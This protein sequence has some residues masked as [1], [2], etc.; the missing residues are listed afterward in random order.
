MRINRL[1]LTRYGHFTDGSIAFPEPAPGM[2]DLHIVYG[3]N[4]SG[5]ST[6]FIALVDLLFGIEPRSKYAF[7]HDY[8]T[9]QIGASLSLTSGTE[10]LIRVKRN[11][12]TLLDRHH[13]PVSEQQ[14]LT[15][16]SG[17]TRES[18]QTMF[19][20]DDQSIEAGGD[21]ILQ[22]RGDFGELLFGASAGLSNLSQRLAEIDAL[23]GAFYRPRA[24]SL[25]LTVLKDELEKLK[26]QRR[27]IDVAASEH[28]HLRANHASRKALYDQAV[29]D[30]ATLQA[31]A[32][33]L[34]RRS[35]ALPLWA[36]LRET[37]RKLAELAAIPVAPAAWHTDFA[38]LQRSEIASNAQVSAIDAEVAAIA[39][40][41]SALGAQPE[42]VQ[43]FDRLEGLA[44]SR[45]RYLT[46]A[47]DLPGR[48]QRLQ[49]D[50]I[51]IGSLLRRLSQDEVD[52]QTLILPTAT[53]GALRGLLE[54]HSGIAGDV[55][56]AKQEHEAATE[57]AET[58]RETL[59]QQMDGITE[60]PASAAS[61]LDKALSTAQ[62]DASHIKIR[63]TEDLLRAA[64]EDVDEAVSA[65]RPWQG[66]AD[67]L[68]RV[69]V[70]SD[71]QMS[72]WKSLAQSIRQTSERLSLEL[73]NARKAARRL[74]AEIDGQR[75]TS[76]LMTH[77]VAAKLRLD[78]DSAWVK[79]RAR[80]DDVTADT[81][82]SALALDDQ[83]T[84][85]R[86]MRL[87]ATT[88]LDQQTVQLKGAKA[89]LVSVE[90]AIAENAKRQATLDAAVRN[91]V[92]ALL[93]GHPD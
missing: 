3:P 33:K 92:A 18:Y 5:K 17:L 12:A 2:P 61:A 74:S 65:L 76:G 8:G 72:D 35:S 41:M 7:L 29:V 54:Q 27:S 20:L 24:R 47:R 88:K 91:C 9:M 56:R 10:E 23:A 63:H 14:L 89:E 70:P 22:S 1:D 71:H 66:S 16:L 87:E 69:A 75:E 42:L 83:A 64:K 21:L 53:V 84:L 6:T 55:R 46:A 77:D 52:P 28:A 81:F 26:E 50:D 48:R 93:A 82:E 51:L 78:R 62:R 67:D 43:A 15:E 49:A 60:A 73:E 44:E 85:T 68:V 40:A 58:H 86:M 90:M 34:A 59:K 30:Q 38:Q 57:I 13:Q 4:E 45:A 19:S 39:E 31:E 80:L 79:H 37:Q 36:R 11:K 25:E 32:D